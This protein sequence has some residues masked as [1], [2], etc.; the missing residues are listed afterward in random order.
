[1]ISI[2]IVGAPGAGKTTLARVLIGKDP[3]LVQKPKWT[4][5]H[6]I[7][8]AGHYSGGTFDGADTVGYNGVKEALVYWQAHL[9]TAR[10]PHP[11][12]FTV[13]DGDRFSHQDALSFVRERS[14][15]TGVVYMDADAATL[16]ARRAA[17]GSTQNETWMKGRATKSERF[18]ELFDPKDRLDLKAGPTSLAM[19]KEVW[20]KFDTPDHFP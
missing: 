8:A 11:I 3:W 20:R 2:F 15:R 9:L 6:A 14:E 4:V 5:N 10:T 7:C 13:F 16:A 17:R 12:R 1:M 18:A 19:E